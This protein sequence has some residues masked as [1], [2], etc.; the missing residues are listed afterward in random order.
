MMSIVISI[1]LA[2]LI[3]P[4]EFGVIGI[5]LAINGF[6]RVFID[7]G[8]S[9][10]IIQSEEVTDN[11]LSSVFYV[12]I[13]IAVTIA[14]LLLM[15]AES[16]SIFFAM[17]DLA[18]PMQVMS[19]T[20]IINSLTTVQT[21]VY[22][23]AL[24]FRSLMKANVV[25]VLISGS[26]GIYLALSGYAIWALVVQVLIASAVYA[27]MIWVQ[28]TWRPKWYYSWDDIRVLWDYGSKILAMGVV[29]GLL[30]RVDV[31]LIGRVF[32]ATDVGLFTRAKSFKQ[33]TIQ[34]STSSMSKVLFPSFSKI[35]RDR[36]RLDEILAKVSKLAISAITLVVG[37]MFLVAEDLFII[38]LNEKWMPAVPLFRLMVLAGI[39]FPL[40][41][42]LLNYIKA[43][44]ESKVFLRIGLIKK[45]MLIPCFVIAYYYGIKVYLLAL[46]VVSIISYLINLA[47]VSSVSD[48]RFHD[49]IKTILPE[50]LLF[51]SVL[52][53]AYLLLDHY[54][55]TNPYLNIGVA[56]ASYL[57]VIVGYHV[58]IDS[59]ALRFGKQQFEKYRVRGYDT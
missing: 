33:M 22:I 37:L 17:P 51:V 30:N 55:T 16:L 12:N 26:I 32:S 23:K 31:F 8:F 40:N 44:G 35:Q 56:S 58:I 7:S 9:N 47:G 14:L 25:S 2:N 28:S 24:D 39:W 36:V 34:L 11:Q 42:I 50:L 41:S 10:A 27:C 52:T 18:L 38:L 49:Q 53:M 13:A 29:E 5:I 19:A 21:S 59:T 3:D 15:S 48:L 54:G 20:L 57:I 6:F 4:A 45:S 1:I 43:V 46:I